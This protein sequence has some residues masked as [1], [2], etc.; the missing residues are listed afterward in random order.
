MFNNNA[1]I[2]ILPD[3][4]PL[5][6]LAPHLLGLPQPGL[7]ISG[8]LDEVEMTREERKTPNEYFMKETFRAKFK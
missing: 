2:R 8:N 5:Y 6:A 4:D 7:N 1:A 3:E